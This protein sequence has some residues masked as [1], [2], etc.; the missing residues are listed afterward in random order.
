MPDV[1][2]AV[3]KYEIDHETK[4]IYFFR[5][6]T[7]VMWNIPDLESGNLLQFLKSYEDSSYTPTV[8]QSESEMMSYTY[9]DPP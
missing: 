4:E 5:E 1:I 6:G 9:T 3:P 7:V 2:H 8:V